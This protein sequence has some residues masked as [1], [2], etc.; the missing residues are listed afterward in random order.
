MK[1][2]T[3][4]LSIILLAI[5]SIL[6]SSTKAVLETNHMYLLAVKETAEE[7]TGVIADLFLRITP[8]NGRVYIETFPLTKYDTQISTR[9][10]RD[11]AC[12]FIDFDCSKYDFFYTIKA[13]SAIIGGPSA[14]AAIAILTISSLLEIPIKESVAITGTINSGGIIGPVSGLIEKIDAAAEKNLTTVLIPQG[15]G[16]TSLAKLEIDLTEYGKEKNITVKEVFDINE[17]FALFTGTKL[18]EKKEL[19][20]DPNY[21]KTMSYLAQLLCNRSKSLLDQISKLEPQTKSLKK[22]KKKAVELYEKG[23]KAKQ[24]RLFYSA[25]SYCFGSNVKSRFVLLSLKKDVNLTKLE[26][27][28]EKF[29]NSLNKTAIKTIT[30]LE[31]YMVVKERLFEARKTLNE[32]SAIELQDEDFFYDAAYVTER[33]YSAAT[34]H[35]FFGK[36]GMEFIFKEGAL[37]EGCLKR[38]G[39]AEE[40]Y[41][42]AKLFLGEELTSTKEE[43]DQAYSDLDNGEYTLCMFRATKAKAEADVVINMIGVH[44]E[45]LDSLLKSKLSIIQRVIAEQQEKGIFPILGYSYYEYASSLKEEEPFLAALYLEYALELSNLDIYFPSA[46]QPETEPEKKEKPLTEAQKKVIYIHIIIF[47]CGFAAGIIVLTLFTRIKTKTK[48]EKMSIKP[49]RASRRSPRRK[50]R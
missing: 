3:L 16:K 30:D 26:E 34:W 9:F 23:I 37:K 8:G 40:R 22:A 41:Q 50:K 46:K 6:S 49:T 21:K 42:Y 29:D 11:I 2:R 19:S 4:L 36:P 38:L 44:K 14:G 35:Q 33:I 7:T 31:S 17:A 45:Q 43:L 15:T 10:A 39:E 48:K 24:D 1:K 5:F 28:I 18:K 20:I 47:F 32:L 12:D 27:E 13:D 25:A